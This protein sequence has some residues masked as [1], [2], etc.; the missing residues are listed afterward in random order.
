MFDV[1]QKRDSELAVKTILTCADLK[2]IRRSI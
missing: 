1:E 2:V